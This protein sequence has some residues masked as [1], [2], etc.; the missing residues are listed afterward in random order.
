MIKVGI[1][2]G[3]G[4]GKTT[5]SKVFETFGVP[6]FYADIEAKKL[7]ETDEVK[8][9]YLSHFGDHVFSDNKLDKTKNKQYSF[10]G[11][12]QT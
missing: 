3:M 4:S 7:L 8:N 6:V 12:R 9:F 10:F 5:I 11:S 1:T 2:G